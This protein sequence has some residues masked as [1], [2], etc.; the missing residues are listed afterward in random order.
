MRLMMA[1]VAAALAIAPSAHAQTQDAAALA[2]ASAE[3]ATQV[4][5]SKAG[6]EPSLS[7]G[8]AALI[9]RAYDAASVRALPLTMELGPVCMAIGDS[10]VAYAEHVGSESDPQIVASAT[11][12]LQDVVVMGTVAGNVCLQRLL[13]ATDIVLGKMPPEARRGAANGLAMMRQGASQTI[14]GT[15]GAAIQPDIRPEN[16]KALLASILENVPVVANSF[17]PAERAALRT[18]VLSYAARTDAAGAAQIRA[19]ADGFAGSGCNALCQLADA[20]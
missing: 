1:M 7:N 5:A 11:A 13:A 20:K 12:R 17:P 19:I 18:T 3:L 16:R 15:I 14:E 8:G 6:S 9:R 2:A 10:I 4:R